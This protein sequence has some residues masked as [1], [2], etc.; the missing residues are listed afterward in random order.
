MSDIETAPLFNKV[1]M[2]Q[3]IETEIEQQTEKLLKTSTDT[4]T[5]MEMQTF[6]PQLL[7][8][9]RDSKNNDYFD[10][11]NNPELPN[12]T[13][14]K[15]EIGSLEVFTDADVHVERKNSGTFVLGILTNNSENKIDSQSTQVEGL[16]ISE[17]LP[18]HDTPDSGLD[19]SLPTVRAT[20]NGIVIF[21]RHMTCELLIYSIIYLACIIFAFG[22]AVYH[23]VS[24]IIGVF[25]KDK[26]EDLDEISNK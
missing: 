3:F 17:K 2:Q 8:K 18:P 23:A 10:D 13:E 24:L 5:D 11:A 21:G 26:S 16:D 4:A 15:E 19:I 9:P 20:R 7:T 14:K 22:Y 6:G 12:D 25:E 1:E